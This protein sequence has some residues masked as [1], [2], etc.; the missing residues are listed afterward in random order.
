MCGN[1]DCAV[2]THGEETIQ[3]GQGKIWMSGANEG[4]AKMKIPV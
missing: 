3:S 2:D 1:E 4:N